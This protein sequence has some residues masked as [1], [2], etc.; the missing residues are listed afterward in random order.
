[1]IRLSLILITS[2]LLLSSC[3]NRQ[4]ADLIVHHGNVYTVDSAFS[5][6][7]S[8]AVR[9]GRIIAI[10]TNEEILGQYTSDS[11]IDAGGKPVY[12]GLIDAHAH[13]MAYGGT[14][15]EVNL[16]GSKSW[17]EAINR[18]QE[19]V[20]AHPSEGWIRG[21]GWDQNAWAGQAFPDNAM[22]NQLFPS[23][24]VLLNRVDG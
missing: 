15:F 8:F 20:K 24:P 2:L 17:E 3:H 6:A 16:N 23:T 22:L 4:R 11:S 13:F 14:L 21:R 12:P 9:D 7:E 1:M 19:F 18:V 10:G 5:K